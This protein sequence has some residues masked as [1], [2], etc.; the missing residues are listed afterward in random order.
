MPVRGKSFR[1]PTSQT[2]ITP[3]TYIL[4][5]KAST[6]TAS[7][8]LKLVPDYTFENAPAPKVIVIPAQSGDAMLEW[9]RKSAKTADVVMS[10]CTGAFILAKTGLLSGKAATTHHGSYGRSPCSSA[11]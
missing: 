3:S 6:V 7:G 10:V 5:P 11:M 1:T 4:W 9:I 8:G 2:A